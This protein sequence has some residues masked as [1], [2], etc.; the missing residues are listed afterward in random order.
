MTQS[1]NQRIAEE[2]YFT[3]SDQT[4]LFYRYWPQEQAKPE[5][6]IVIFH[7]GHE[8]SGRIQHVVDELGFPD[9]PMFAWDARGHG[10]TER[11]RGYSPS[12]GT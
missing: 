7:R 5:K 9:I 2:H 8:H 1:Y 4:S 6:A 3:T 12:M 11:P 10:K